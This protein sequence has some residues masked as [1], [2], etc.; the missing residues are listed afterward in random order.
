MC[1][2]QIKK[3]KF[4]KLLTQI[5][6]YKIVIYLIFLSS[7]YESFTV[8]NLLKIILPFSYIDKNFIG[9]FLIFYLCIP[10]L[11][12]LVTNMTKKQHKLLL[13]LSLS[14]Y[15]IIGTVLNITFNYITWFC[16][17]FFI[18]S[19]IRL[20]PIS[21]FEN[22]KFWLIC[23]LIS[24]LF[25]CLSIICMLWVAVRFGKYNPYFFVSDSNK[26]FAVSTSICSFMLFKNLR[27]KSN[28]F[29]N[30]V[31]S[32]CFGVLLIHANSDTMRRW[33]WNDMLHNVEIYNSQYYI[34]HP[35]VSAI[36]IFIICSAIE[37]IRGNLFNLK[38]IIT[39]KEVNNN[40]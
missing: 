11:N 29:I 3:K 32:T 23:T 30:I 25:S 35:I 4:I 7:R 20:Y 40:D 1:K 18:A 39:K 33:L 2:T 13:A 22:T 19:Y 34:I 36:C 38:K 6:F 17:L 10:F 8:K 15:V 28:S 31:A 14:V 5:Y 37:W 12:V 24:I 9:C 16:I 26:I 21:L 27:M